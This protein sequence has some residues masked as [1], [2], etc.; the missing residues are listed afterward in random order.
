MEKGDADADD[1][2]R[3][4]TADQQQKAD[5]EAQTD[6]GDDE[7]AVVMGVEAFGG[8][9]P[10]H[11]RQRGQD[12]GDHPNAHDRMDRLLLGVTQPGRRYRRFNIKILRSQRAEEDYSH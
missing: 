7:A 9:V 11:G 6:L 5:A 4:A 3:Y 12:E 8:I 10:A 2:H 1:A